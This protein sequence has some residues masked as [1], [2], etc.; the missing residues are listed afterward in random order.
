MLATAHTPYTCTHL[1]IVVGHGAPVVALPTGCQRQIHAGPWILARQQRVP[2]G[3]YNSSRRH[4]EG[5]LATHRVTVSLPVK[6]EA[7]G[8]LYGIIA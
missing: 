4:E 5:V 3:V 7:C 6:Q 1:Q 2:P 8:I